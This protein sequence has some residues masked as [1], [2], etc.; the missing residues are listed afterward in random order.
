MAFDYYV[1]S[2]NLHHLVIKGSLPKI[3]QIVQGV[4]NC[5]LLLGV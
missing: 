1:H 2:M 5:F 4:V 3:A